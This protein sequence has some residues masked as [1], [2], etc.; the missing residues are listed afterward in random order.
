MRLSLFS[1][2]KVKLRFNIQ[3]TKTANTKDIS[4]EINTLKS[5]KLTR[6]NNI[7]E[8][9][10]K[11]IVPM[12]ENF[13]NCFKFYKVLCSNSSLLKCE[14]ESSI[15]AKEKNI[16]EIKPKPVAKIAKGT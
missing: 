3:V 16:I 1:F 9:T 2:K 11:P 15:I 10:I 7:E 14:I 13:K 5:K 6:Y 8:S 4:L 12:K